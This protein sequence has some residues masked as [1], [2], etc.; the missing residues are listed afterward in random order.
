MSALS[1]RLLENLS[2]W[3]GFLE[4]KGRLTYNGVLGL[5]CGYHALRGDSSNYVPLGLP[6]EGKPE[7]SKGPPV[8]LAETIS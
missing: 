6:S 5:V 8:V 3:V 4:L 7:G 1:D 2:D